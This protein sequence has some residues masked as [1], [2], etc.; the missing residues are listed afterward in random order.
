MFNKTAATLKRTNGQTLTEY[1]LIITL[2]AIGALV[3]FGG[4]SAGT[5][6]LFSRIVGLLP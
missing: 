1:A 5:Q 3:A 6:G 4:L 2:I